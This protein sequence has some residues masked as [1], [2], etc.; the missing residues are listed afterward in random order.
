MSAGRDLLLF[1]RGLKEWLVP[2][3]ATLEWM[4]EG[5][6]IKTVD[7]EDDTPEAVAAS[8]VVVDL[9]VLHLRWL[10]AQMKD[11]NQA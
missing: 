7:V 3:V 5:G 4:A 11:P 9:I 2:P 8:L 10:R 6:E 1:T